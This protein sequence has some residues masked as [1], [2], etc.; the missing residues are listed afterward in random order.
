MAMLEGM[1]CVDLTV[2]AIKSHPPEALGISGGIVTAPTVM[3]LHD[4]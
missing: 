2:S 4:P 1:G 3:E